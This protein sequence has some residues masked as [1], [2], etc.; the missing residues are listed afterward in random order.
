MADFSKFKIGNTSYNVK[1]ANAGRSFDQPLKGTLALKNAANQQIDATLLNLDGSLADVTIDSNTL[2]DGD[3][4]AYD[5]NA[6]EW[7]NKASGGGG[8]SGSVISIIMYSAH[9]TLND[10]ATT[11]PVSIGIDNIFSNGT[12][13]SSMASLLDALNRALTIDPSTDIKLSIK[14][15]DFVAEVTHYSVNQGDARILFSIVDAQQGRTYR[16]TA[17]FNEFSSSIT[18]NQSMDT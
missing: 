12:A 1:D 7:V 11:S 4:L 17:L 6:Q 2:A 9:T 5:A 15:A 10:L 13:G 3:V 8:G 18:A 16:K 14:G